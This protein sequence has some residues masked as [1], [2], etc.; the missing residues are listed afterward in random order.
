VTARTL[1]LAHR[2]DWRLAPE[3]TIRA[4]EL[5]LDIAACDGLEFDVRL[6]RDGVPVLLHDVTLQRVQG[7]PDR[8]DE[9]DAE[10]LDALGVPA[11]SDALAAID[12]SRPAAFLDIEL[13]GPDHA[14]PTAEVLVAAR[15]T[16]P[17]DAV[18]SSFDPECLVAMRDLLPDWGRWL[19]ADALSTSTLRLA[20]DLGCT[21]VSARHWS[22]DAASLTDAADAGLEVAGWTVRDVATWSRLAAL[23]IR[24]VCVEAEALDG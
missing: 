5:A 6:S 16:A 21:G 4:L 12:D 23:G 1:R 22:I 17:A 20:V 3:N 9:L 2:G 11:L 15:G 19:N 7:V 24:A 8:V 10:A 13:K 18:V 14:A